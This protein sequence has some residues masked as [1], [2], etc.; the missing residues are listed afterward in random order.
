MENGQP[1]SDLKR[2]FDQAWAE[3]I[4]PLGVIIVL[5]LGYGAYK[6]DLIGE[7][8]AGVVLVTAVVLGLLAFGFFPG[9]RL[10]RTSGDRMSMI[11]LCL[12]ALAGAGWPTL[13]VAWSP[14]PLASGQLTTE[15]PKIELQTGSDGPYELMV[16]GRFKQAGASD[17]EAS[18]TIE[19]SGD[20]GTDKVAGDIHR[21]THRYR[22]SRKGGTSASVEEH[23]DNVHRLNT[24][25]GGKIT[26]A[27]DGIDDTL[28]HGLQVSVR[29]GGPR[30]EI[31]WVLSALAVLLGLLLDVRL[32]VDVREEDRKVRAPRREGSY[33][34]P[35]TAMLLVFS[36]NYVFE[37]TPSAVVRSAI[38][39]LVLALLLGGGGGWL[40]MSFARLTMRPKRK[41]PAAG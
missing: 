29:P 3:W 20:S 30:P 4:Q 37:A 15:Q 7:R 28:D 39:A 2:W 14:S 16:S 41:R 32:V 13:R 5:G 22:T 31:F 11:V 17:A 40:V 21:A 36:V 35:A 34:T 12:L 24:V 6:L 38:G 10:A 33:L 18:Y 8:A 25:R 26:V 19:V 27:C 23:T 9:W 1:Q